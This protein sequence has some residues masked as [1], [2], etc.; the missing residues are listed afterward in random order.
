MT[1]VLGT[2]FS[3]FRVALSCFHL[4][5][6]VF[7]IFVKQKI[8]AAPPADELERQT[9]QFYTNGCEAIAMLISSDRFGVAI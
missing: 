9:G 2:G 7:D 3:L 8:N 1:P 6:G 4:R 5:G